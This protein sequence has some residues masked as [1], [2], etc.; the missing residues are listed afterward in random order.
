VE[1]EIADRYMAGGSDRADR[2]GGGIALVLITGLLG[3]RRHQLGDVIVALV[4]LR[5][6]LF[7][8]RHVAFEVLLGDR[9]AEERRGIGEADR[10]RDDPGRSIDQEKADF[11]MF[12]RQEHDPAGH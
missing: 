9:L 7:A 10:L 4:H 3:R 5:H 12:Q 8:R 6:P 1:T 11:G 2:A